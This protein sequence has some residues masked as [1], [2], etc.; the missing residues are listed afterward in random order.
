[1]QLSF[2]FHLNIT[3]V[4]GES[5]LSEM[6]LQHWGNHVMEPNITFT[7]IIMQSLLLMYK[8]WQLSIAAPTLLSNLVHARMVLF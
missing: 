1:M 4:I 3:T 8:N 5:Y 2:I 7:K 6:L